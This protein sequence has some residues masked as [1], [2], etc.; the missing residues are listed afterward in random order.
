MD[1]SMKTSPA[2]PVRRL[3]S[4]P[5]GAM[6]RHWR[7]LRGK[8]QLDLS[9]DAGVSQRHISFVESG[10][11]LP[12][13]QML[14]DLAEA[15]GIPLRERNALLVAAGYAPVYSGEPLDAPGLSR[16]TAA[17]QRMLKQN[18]PYPA[19]VMD[20]G[21]NVLLANEASPRFFGCFVNLNARQ[22]PR[23]LLHLMFDPAGMRP[24]MADW[25][26]TAR[27][28]L[29][30]VH[31]EAL[32]RVIDPDLRRLLDDLGRYPGVDPAWRMP[33]SGNDEPM[34]PLGFVKDGLTLRYFS[35]ITTVGTPQAVAAEELRLECM[36]P[37]DDETEARHAS[38]IARSGHLH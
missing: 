15:L 23:N 28:L 8:S 35:L 24:F 14:L 19:V 25:P 22:E 17:L 33:R 4:E 20:R 30:R 21:W 3:G 36:I 7:D 26:Q 6:L 13:R 1:D 37:A 11:S 12:S 18:E 31:R 38:L 16:I 29:S 10:R 27:M 32:G 9:L 2:A 34:I 5:A